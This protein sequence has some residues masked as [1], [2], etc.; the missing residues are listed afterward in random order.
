MKS[1][2]DNPQALAE[3][4]SAATLAARRSLG[5]AG[6]LPLA[7]VAFGL[8]RVANSTGLIAAE[9]VA[10]VVLSA[11]VGLGAGVGLAGSV[12]ALVQVMVAQRSL[13]LA[14]AGLGVRSLDPGPGWASW[15]WFVPLANLVVPARSLRQV[16]RAAQAD[17]RRPLD[18]LLRRWWLLSLVVVVLATLAH[19]ATLTGVDSA[20]LDAE[21]V[22]ELAMVAAGGTW[23]LALLH[24]ATVLPLLAAHLSET[25]MLVAV[26][27]RQQPLVFTDVTSLARWLDETLAPPFDPGPLA[28]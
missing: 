15:S 4:A 27:G 14:V 16:A 17:A 8:I 6:A 28:Q 25:A 20:S 5:I 9:G 2:V 19:P 22:A 23:L 21:R 3:A 11:A 26:A 18:R 7:L 24:L 1:R 13:L 10:E 12:V